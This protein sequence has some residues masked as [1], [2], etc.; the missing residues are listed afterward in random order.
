MFDFQE[1]LLGSGPSSIS[2][3]LQRPSPLS[4]L[5]F[6]LCL[7]LSLLLPL[8]LV[9]LVLLVL[10]P[11]LNQ[12][13]LMHYQRRMGLAGQPFIALK[14][15]TM[16]PA[17]VSKRGAFD[18]LEEDRISRLGRLMRK[19]RVDELPQII[20]VLRAEM[21]LIGPRPD[22]YDHASVYLQNVPGYA[23]RHQIMP[24]ISGYAQTEVGYVDGIDGIERKVAADLY[25][26]THASLRFDLWIAWRTLCVVAGLKGR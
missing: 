14:F 22:L 6:D 10:N 5:M 16:V 19:L 26:I 9:A 23:A 4:K 11:F 17:L 24:G 1:D 20:N 12:G 18:A 2:V 13:P 7:S 3:S 25:Y 15:R 8:A 21:S